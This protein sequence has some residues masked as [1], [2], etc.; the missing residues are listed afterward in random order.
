MATG[1]EQSSGT[2]NKHNMNINDGIVSSKTKRIHNFI[3][4]RT[5]SMQSSFCILGQLGKYNIY[6]N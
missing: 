4:P 5:A 3:P 6:R 2:F 1:G